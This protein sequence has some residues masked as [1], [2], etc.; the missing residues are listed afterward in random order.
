MREGGQDWEKTTRWGSTATALYVGAL[1][2]KLS[3]PTNI[4]FKKK[5]K[6]NGFA[7]S[8]L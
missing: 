8:S 2:T 7:F 3:A 1:S 5:L 6:C 4:G